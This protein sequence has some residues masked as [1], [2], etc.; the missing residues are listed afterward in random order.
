M[1]YF[2]FFSS[3]LIFITSCSYIDSK[4]GDYYYYKAK[5]IS[6]K[7]EVTE[8]EI[9]D[10][11]N[12]MIKA[13]ERKK[14]IPEAIDIVD[15]VTEASVKSG[16]LK[17]YD[18][19]FKF[20]KKYI[21]TNPYAWNVYLNMIN[22]FAVKGDVYNLKNFADDFDKNSSLKPE[23]KLLSFI[24]KAN[25][26]YW[27]ESYGYLSINDD[28]DTF[29]NYLD[30]YCKAFKDLND[31]ILIDKEGY[32]RDS[33][34][35]TYYY[36]NTLVN[37]L[38]SKEN[39]I[40]KNCELGKKIKSDQNYYK[41]IRYFIIA[42]KYLSKQ[43]YSNA[44][45]YYKAA[46]NLNEDFV[47]AR[48]G[49]IEAEFQ[50]LLSI[51]LMKKN[52][53]ELI[54][55]VNDKIDEINRIIKKIN[56]GFVLNVPFVASDKIISSLYTLKSAMI[57]VIYENEKNENKKSLYFKDLNISLNEAIK[58]DPSNRLAKDLY[59]RFINK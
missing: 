1:R 38:I 5:K 13:V 16:Y 3:I 19:Q 46:L 45:I 6:A 10:F 50:N 59:E 25:L 55:F 26:L 34:T 40:I 28:Y 29:I 12:Y 56:N 7:E 48:K 4:I 57:S 47:E 30:N 8:S 36:Y 44:I 52:N 11:F 51:S 31:V 18:Y 53:E 41:T 39:F 21:E 33:D 27:F 49:L 32:F 17:A 54:E 24:T 35:N 37:D 42:N 58:Y 22:I 14:N 2:V 15:N 43:E 9:E 20:Y 23:F